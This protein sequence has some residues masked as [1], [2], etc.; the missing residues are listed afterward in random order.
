MGQGIEVVDERGHL[1][2]VLQRVL[3][4]IK[5]AVPFCGHFVDGFQNDAA[6]TGIDVVEQDFGMVLLLAKLYFKPFGHARLSG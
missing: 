5:D 2:L 3:K 1:L 6:T 4:H